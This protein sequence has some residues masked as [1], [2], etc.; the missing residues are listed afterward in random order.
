MELN[1]TIFRLHLCPSFHRW[2]VMAHWEQ[3]ESGLGIKVGAASPS[4]RGERALSD[5]SVDSKG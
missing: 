4:G 5:G 1:P 3:H 2:L